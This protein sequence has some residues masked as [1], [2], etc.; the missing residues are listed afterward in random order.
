MKTFYFLFVLTVFLNENTALGSAI[1]TSSPESTD[2]AKAILEDGGNAID[3]ACAAFFVQAVT[4]SYFTGLGGGG[5]AVLED[6][7]RVFHYD[8][9]E[10]A[11]V[12][13]NQKLPNSWSLRNTGG[14]SVGVPGNVAGCNEL[15]QKHGKKKWK[16]VL[17][18]SI[19]YAKNGFNVSQLYEEELA[20]QWN[21]INPFEQT[22]QIYQGKEGKGLKKGEI[23]KQPLLADTLERLANEGSDSFYKG[24]L[25][26]EWTQSA[27]E[28]GSL[29][30]ESDLKN[31][32][33]IPRKTVHFEFGKFSAET[34][35]PS[36]AAGFMVGGV[37][38]F[39]DHYHTIY[40]T[41]SESVVARKIIEI[42]TIRHFSELRD[43]IISDSSRTKMDLS[44]WFNSKKEKK[45]WKILEVNIKDR[46]SKLED[47]V[48][49]IN[50]KTKSVPEKGNSHTSN[51][52]VIDNQGNAIALTTSVG[53][54]FGSG[55]SVS[56]L[57]FILNST[58]GDFSPEPDSINTPGPGLRPRSNISP[59]LVYEKTKNGKKLIAILGAAGG[60]LIPQSI[61]Q[62]FQ[63]YFIYNLSGKD[64]IR[65][66]RISVSNSGSVE[67]EK[68]ASNLW[69]TQLKKA[70]YEVSQT[71]VIWAV[72][73]GIVRKN[74]SSQWEAVS[75]SRYDGKAWSDNN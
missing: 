15:I 57:G 36:S 6:K 63:N 40:G 23:L 16:E 20:E 54:I 53:N 19:K 48:L 75:E 49:L 24:A 9:R 67:I 41:P 60:P 61:V 14:I 35:S 71:D 45:S 62:F 51:I 13:V 70:G 30:T 66:P 25:A 38:R 12:K 68:S 52:S 64:A 10:A 33:V 73:N 28:S 26:K 18:S 65:S 59:T 17:A 74:P 22:R 69:Y 7:G 50:K 2:A 34:A 31:Y 37:L 46:L 43:K 3:A 29:I 39:L 11:P 32:K 5:F 4:Q 27:N 8:F 1:A 47:H 55:I 56:K 58:L 21:R 44:I 42:E 72:F